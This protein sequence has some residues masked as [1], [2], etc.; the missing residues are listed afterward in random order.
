MLKDEHGNYISDDNVKAEMFNS[1]F[2]S[3]FTRDDGIVLEYQKLNVNE[4]LHDV[5][6]TYDK[7][8]S[9][10]KTLKNKSSTGPDGLSP[11][12]IKSLEDSICLPLLLIFNASI[13]SGIIHT[14]LKS[15]LV[16]PVFKK[17]LSS[18]VK[19][20]RP[21]FL[22]CVCCRLMES[23]INETIISF[24]LANKLITKH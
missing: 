23:I 15:A 12:V 5:T 20:Y 21:I 10:I 2:T 9:A 1:F 13:L 3:V 7:V 11:I 22:T 17:G 19:N 6:F 24:L 14:K 16:T 18:S 8:L 4:T